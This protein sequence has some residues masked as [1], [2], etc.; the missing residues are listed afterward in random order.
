MSKS[1]IQ[2][3]IDDQV[4]ES[5]DPTKFYVTKKS[6]L[7]RLLVSLAGNWLVFLALW[8]AVIS[9]FLPYQIGLIDELNK[10]NNLALVLTTS[11]FFSI[12]AQP[13]AGALSDRTRSKWGRRSLWI[14]GGSLFGAL[15]LVGLSLQ[16]TIVGVLIC[17]IGVAVVLNFANGPLAT[18]IADRFEPERRGVAS[19]IIG[20]SQTAGGT[21]GI[22]AAGAILTAWNVRAGYL[23]FAAAIFII[24]WTFVLLNR[25]PSTENIAR[26]P[27]KIGEFLKGFWV[28]PRKYPDFGWAFLGRFMMYLGYQGTTAY[29]LYILADYIGMG[30]DSAATTIGTVSAV[31]MVGLIVS[32]LVSGWLSDVFKRRKPFVFAATVIISIA[33][34]MP[35]IFPNMAGIYLYAILMGL[36][37]GAYMSIDLALMSEVLPEGG[38]D[39]GKDMGVLTIA[40]QVPQTL[41]PLICATLLGL[42][43]GN[44]ASIFIFGM[45]VVFSSSFF[46]LPIKSVK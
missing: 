32:G 13:L 40:T 18:V 1:D 39:A 27:F 2:K 36:G 14:M 38:A 22:M 43:G 34:A 17:Y 16:T 46:V 44:Y 28:S 5:I 12:F 9:V 26:K 30:M 6:R 29:L 24:C 8:N 33:L 35:L 3:Q 10:E 4:G 21:I 11:T 42:F 41:S 23:I 7:V 25:E 20:A 37:Y 19:G 15:I 31:Q 45:I